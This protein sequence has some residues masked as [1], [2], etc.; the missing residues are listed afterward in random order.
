[1]KKITVIAAAMLTAISCSKIESKG[2]KITMQSDVNSS[3]NEISISNAITLK[4]SDQM[5]IGKISVT[6]HENIHQYIIISNDSDELTI[7][8]KDGNYKDL[9]IEVVA[10]SMQYNDIEA[11]GACNIKIDGA[12]ASFDKYEI[13]LSGASS[14]SG[15]MDITNLLS[16]DLS[17]TSEVNISGKSTR[18]EAELSGA[19]TLYDTS[20]SCNTLDVDMSG[21][22]KIHMSVSDSITGELSGASSLKY[23]GTPTISVETSGASTVGSL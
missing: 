8:L 1:M 10:S 9:Y 19:S 2:D 15:T 7:Q 16:I 11:S 21:A 18:C 5:Q 20:F 3:T 6:A 12:P 13:D 23:R 22:S 4:L 17:G 14:F